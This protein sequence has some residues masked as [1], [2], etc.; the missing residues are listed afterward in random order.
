MTSTIK[1]NRDGAWA[2]VPNQ[3]SNTIATLTYLVRNGVC[4]VDIYDNSSY[5]WTKGSWVTLG[6]LPVGCRPSTTVYGSWSNRDGH[7]GECVVTAAGAVMFNSN[8]TGKVF[9]S[10]SLA[11]PLA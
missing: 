9:V 8:Y 10:A 6:T 3:P 2:N 4:Y 5:S 7:G 11:V 1:G